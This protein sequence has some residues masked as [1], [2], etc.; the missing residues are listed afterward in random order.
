MSSEED[1]M[2]H[3]REAAIAQIADGIA[4]LTKAGDRD[5]EL[6]KKVIAA[7]LESHESRGDTIAAA[8]GARASCKITNVSVSCASAKAG[9][10]VAP[11][12]SRPPIRWGGSESVTILGCTVSVEYECSA[13]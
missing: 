6:V 2:S 13:S 10:G 9:A 5:P 12:E 4:A 8:A 7:V 3:H 1:E 11:A